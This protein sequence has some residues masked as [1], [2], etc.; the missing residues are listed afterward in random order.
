MHTGKQ[1][2][3]SALALAT[4]LA[5]AAGLA[6][7][8][9]EA[10]FITKN[11]KV[12]GTDFYMF[13]SYEA[14]RTGYVTILANYIPVQD[15]YG[16]P[17]YFT[18]DPDAIYEVHIDNDGDGIEDLTFQFD[19]DTQLANGGTGV[20]LPIGGKM[21]N[22]PLPVA[23]PLSAPGD[24][25]QNVI[26]TFKLGVIR[27][28]R[29]ATTP[30]LAT[31][32]ADSST[33][34]HKP[35]DNAGTKTIP[36]YANYASQFVYNFDVPGCTPTGVG[37][38][39]HARV[40][41]GQRKEGFA[42][43]LGQVFDLVNMGVSALG[44]T[45][46]NGQADLTGAADQGKNIVDDKN[47][48]TLALEIPAS[49][50]TKDSSHPIIAGWTTASMRQAR[51]LNPTATFS[52]PAREGGPWV[53]VS[54][55]G[56]PLVNE[57]V[58][59]LKDKDK[60]NGSEPKDDGQFADYVTNPSLPILVEL[61]FGATGALA[62]TAYPRADLVAA[63]LNGVPSVNVLSS[64]LYEALRL[65]TAVPATARASQSPLGAATCFDPPA[66]NAHGPTLN[67]A[68]NGCDPAG[69][70]NGRRPGDDTVDIELR[71][72]MGFLLDQN[73]API[74]G[75]PLVDGAATNASQFG[76]AFPYLANPIPGS[77]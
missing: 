25:N 13:N 23:G 40:F 46:A 2:L 70:P 43:N 69:F 73:H 38:G 5:P 57:I 27:G 74:R 64:T 21:I 3:G 39:T 60:F 22:I 47:V 67:L 30:T 29:R 63:F 9:R 12:D 49:C 48:T 42:V 56:M 35:F 16:G 55:L 17:N 51:V 1:L 20:E 6:S 61:V 76:T 10:P 26:E 44:V 68:R 36:N 45:P 18:L 53:Q 62:P 77:P 59:G 11:P 72:A 54:R 8:H 41:V 28:P 75:A 15:A 71:V 65:N 50:L 4:V 7:S 52:T 37:S 34:F 14:S 58:I 33:T 66:D 32:L 31:N 24:A 19:F